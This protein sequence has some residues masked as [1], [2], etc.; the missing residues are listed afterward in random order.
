MEIQ[1][2]MVKL[3]AAARGQ[4]AVCCSV[5]CSVEVQRC[6]LQC[7]SSEV[8]VAVLKFR[9]LSWHIEVSRH[10]LSS[11][12]TYWGLSTH[13]VIFF[14]RK[15]TWMQWQ[16]AVRRG[17]GLRSCPNMTPNHLQTWHQMRSCLKMEPNLFSKWSSKSS[18]AYWR[19]RATRERTQI[20][21]TRDSPNGSDEFV[22]RSILKI[23]TFHKNISG[24]GHYC[25]HSICFSTGAGRLALMSIDQTARKL[26][27][28]R[29]LK[30]NSKKIQ[31]M[32]KSAV[33]LSIA[34]R[35]RLALITND[36]TG[37]RASLASHS[38]VKCVRHDS[39]M[40]ET[41]LVDACDTT[42]SNVWKM[43]REAMCER[44]FV[45]LAPGRTHTNLVIMCEKWLF[46]TL[47]TFT[48]VCVT[49]LVHAC[50]TWLIR[51]TYL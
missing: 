31:E 10:I 38:G 35:G 30:Q 51:C 20:D 46:H 41:W 18:A 48:R 42:C 16:Y 29:K 5:C 47:S 21:L 26:C 22:V 32:E 27:K 9:G 39:L 4:L 45:K 36:E 15:W 6:V 2:N 11:L 34:A 33:S 37:A 50:E 25:P 17:G 1:M 19:E 14:P 8:C 12:T 40:R 28:N 44:W 43:I 23:K 49:W 13:I 3:S 7:W 24:N